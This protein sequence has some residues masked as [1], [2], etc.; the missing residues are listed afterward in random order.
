MHLINGRPDQTYD[1]IFG[2]D[3]SK[4]QGAS[5]SVVSVLCAQTREKVAEFA[6][7][8]TPPYEL[9]RVV[10]AASLW[11]GGAQRGG[12]PL[13]IWEANGPGWD[14]GRVFVRTLQYPNYYVD[15]SSGTITEKTGKRYGWH[16]S[17]EK[18]EQVLGILRRAYAHSGVINHSGSALDE[19]LSYIHY[20][21]GGIGP[22][23]FLKESESAR[24]THGDRVIA[25][26]LM[27]LGVEDAPRTVNKELVPPMRSFAYRRRVALSRRAASLQPWAKTFDWRI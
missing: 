26:M 10:A 3:P 18:K 2:I 5:N 14:F 15:K 22:A 24:L 20:E 8:N 1:Y 7:A 17:R 16:S 23:D 6:D 21:D 25:D 27:L 11:F 19:A 9:A 13:V 4:G 12:K